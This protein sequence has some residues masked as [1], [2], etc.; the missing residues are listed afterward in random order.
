MQKNSTKKIKTFTVG[1]DEKQYDESLYANKIS[2][3]LGTNHHEII[4]NLPNE[5]Q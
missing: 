1:F 4:V 5:T 2:R 3:S